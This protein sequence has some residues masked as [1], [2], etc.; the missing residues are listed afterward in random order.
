[1]QSCS[2]CQDQVREH[3][4]RS[5]CARNRDVTEQANSRPVCSRKAHMHSAASAPRMAFIAMMAQPQE[6][7]ASSVGSLQPLPAG[8]SRQPY[9]ICKER[10]THASC[11]TPMNVKV[12]IKPGTTMHVLQTISTAAAACG[13]LCTKGVH[14][15][16]VPPASWPSRAKRSPEMSALSAACCSDCGGG[17]CCCCPPAASSMPALRRI[18]CRSKVTI[19]R[20]VC[21]HFSSRTAMHTMPLH[22][23]PVTISSMRAANPYNRRCLLLT[24]APPRRQLRVQ[25]QRT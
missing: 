4:M 7:D 16:L 9:A 8:T 15:Q 24:A 6:R 20:S 5:H 22:V 3:H 14:A 18:A 10:C 21:L 11:E 2:M 23:S 17:G 25:H 13:P 12:C 19:Q 1:M